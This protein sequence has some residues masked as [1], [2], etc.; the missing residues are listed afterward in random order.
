MGRQLAYNDDFGGT[1]NSQITFTATYTGLYFLDVAGYSASVGNY[2]LSATDLTPA[3]ADIAGNA[4]TVALLAVGANA[5][6]TIGFAGDHDWFRIDLQAGHQ[7]RFNAGGFNTALT[8]RDS[9]GQQL[10]FNDD[11]NGT[12]NSEITFSA[13]STGTY[14]LD[15]Q[16]WNNLTGTYTLGATDTTPTD[17][18]ATTQTSAALAVGS[19]LSSNIGV[20]YDRDWFRID[21]QAGHQYR[22]NAGGIDTTL[23]LKD[24]AGQQLAFNDDSLG[25]NSEITFLANST[26][27]YYLDVAGHFNTT[28]SYTLKA[29]DTALPDVAAGTQTSNSI[30]VG[31]IVTSNSGWMYDHDWFRITLVQGHQYQFDAA[32][33]DINTG[34]T[35]GFDANLGL[36]RAD[37]SYIAQDSNASTAAQ[38]RFTAEYTGAYYLDVSGGLSTPLGSYVL[39]STDLS[40]PPPSPSPSLYVN[41]I[42]ADTQTSANLAVG[43]SASSDIGFSN[44]HDWFRI[45]LQAGHRYQFNVGGFDPTLALRNEAGQQIAFNDDSNGSRH[46]EITFL[47][48]STG[49]HYLDVGEWASNSTG[50]YTIQAVLVA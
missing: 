38:I 18:L 20:A 39:Q 36:T 21:L 22:F 2:G 30:A 14:F 24:S 13:G 46:S 50:A 33:I 5:S 42:L 7:Y 35:N 3:P 4:Q 32:G 19:S 37:G 11:S 47:A 40:S 44:D 43:A 34:Q 31:G 12:L 26:G 45:N 28:G 48:T 16:G 1:L 49:I 29:T 9:A 10:A 6:S 25:P 8:L 27:T 17:I 15:V 41:D 23:A